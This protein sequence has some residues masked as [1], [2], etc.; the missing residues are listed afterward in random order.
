MAIITAQ[1][2]Q[3]EYGTIPESASKYF[4]TVWSMYLSDPYDL[5]SGDE[6]KGEIIRVKEGEREVLDLTGK[7]ITLILDKSAIVD[8]LYISKTDWSMLFRERGLVT[9]GYEL[10]LRL[11]Q[12]IRKTTKEKEELFTKKDITVY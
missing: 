9:A 8:R 2:V 12:A 1:K 10:A 11:T 3:I 4:I 7:E 5:I 6:I